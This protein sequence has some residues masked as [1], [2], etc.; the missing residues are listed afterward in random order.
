MAII[1]FCPL[2]PILLKNL[3]ECLFF[4]EFLLLK[5]FFLSKVSLYAEYDLRFFLKIVIEKAVAVAKTANR[6]KCPITRAV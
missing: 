2:S 3:Y 4:Y 1:S 6:L 5:I